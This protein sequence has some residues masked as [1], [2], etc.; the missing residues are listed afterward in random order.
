[1]AYHVAYSAA[2]DVVSEAAIF[3]C[4]G[5]EP[6]RQAIMMI[7]VASYEALTTAQKQDPNI[8]LV[9]YP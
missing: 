9:I 8:L 5:I 2:R 3:G 1:M 4:S 7:S 6:S